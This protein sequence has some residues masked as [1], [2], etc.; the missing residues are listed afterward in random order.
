MAW[1]QRV[2]V[3]PSISIP[4]LRTEGRMDRQLRTAAF[5]GQAHRDG[6]PAA[7]AKFCA[8]NGLRGAPAADNVG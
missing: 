3:Q 7:V 8:Q 2:P 4:A 5:T 1:R 6:G